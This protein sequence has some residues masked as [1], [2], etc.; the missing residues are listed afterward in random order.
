MKSIGPS[1][2]W[3]SICQ[4]GSPTS[5]VSFCTSTGH[6]P[7]GENQS[8]PAY[9]EQLA[10]LTGLLPNSLVRLALIAAPSLV[11]FRAGDIW[12]MARKKEIMMSQKFRK[13]LHLDQFAR[14][15][16]PNLRMDAIK[17]YEGRKFITWLRGCVNAT[18]AVE[19]YSR[20]ES[21]ILASTRK[22]RPGKTDE[23]P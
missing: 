20:G 9:P 14:S 8:W 4:L 1:E 15:Y 13:M 6:S 16:E 17:W 19:L 10:T 3:R 23:D 2:A 12:K 5:N 7:K 11:D 22:T 21:P 18:V